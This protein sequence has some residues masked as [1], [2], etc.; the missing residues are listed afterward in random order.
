MGFCPLS[1]LSCFIQM[2]TSFSVAVFVGMS[3]LWFEG[4]IKMH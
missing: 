4:Q 2:E 1:P 3:V